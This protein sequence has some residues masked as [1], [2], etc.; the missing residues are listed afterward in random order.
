MKLEDHIK[1]GL[2]NL[3]VGFAILIAAVM[4]AHA[5]FTCD[6]ITFGNL[7]LWVSFCMA[8]MSMPFFI[9]GFR[10]INKGNK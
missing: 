4:F 10:I 3:I 1:Q 8:L 9:D 2:N 5:A 7:S 6:D